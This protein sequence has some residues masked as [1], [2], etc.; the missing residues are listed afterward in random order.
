M[1]S[2]VSVFLYNSKDN[3]VYYQQN[4]GPLSSC[5]LK[6]VIERRLVEDG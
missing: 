3:E 2:G 1:G 6:T 4:L 5:M